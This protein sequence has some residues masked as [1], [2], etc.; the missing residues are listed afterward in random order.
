MPSAPQAPIE[1]KLVS[2]EQKRK[3]MFEPTQAASA[4]IRWA[5][6]ISG[7]AFTALATLFLFGEGFPNVFVQPTEVVLEFLALGMMLVGFLLGW[8]WEAIGGGLALLGFGLFCVVEL[9][10]NGAFPGG[11]IPLFAIPGILLLIS[12][13]VSGDSRTRGT[14]FGASPATD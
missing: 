11:A 14:N 12:H 2:C 3:L 10:V 8:R 6:R 13:A 4:G 5:A 1:K 9:I 7:L